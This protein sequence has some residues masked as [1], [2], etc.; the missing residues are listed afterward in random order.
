MTAH[1]T[2]ANHD[3]WWVHDANAGLLHALPKV[4]VDP[5]VEG[6][7]DA[8]RDGGITTRVACGQ[9][10]TWRWPGMISRMALPRCPGCCDQLGIPHGTGAPANDPRLQ[11]EARVQERPLCPPSTEE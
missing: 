5:D 2:P 11:L 7:L 3:H 6:K 9:D 10:N 8:F 4:A 1:P